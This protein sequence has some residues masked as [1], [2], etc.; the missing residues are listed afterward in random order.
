M[1][2]IVLPDYNLIF[3]ECAKK[4]VARHAKY[5]NSWM[6]SQPENYW[7][8]RTQNEVEE[9]FAAQTTAERKAEI[10]DAIN[11]LCMWYMNEA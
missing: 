9:V 6:Q 11:I 5:G 10:I 8:E 7:K 4:A 3:G 1:D 2:G